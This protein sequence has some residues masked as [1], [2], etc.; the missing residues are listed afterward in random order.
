MTAM[1]AGCSCCVFRTKSTVQSSEATA[2][3]LRKHPGF[4]FWVVY[5]GAHAQLCAAAQ[6]SQCSP[7]VDRDKLFQLQLAARL[8]GVLLGSTSTSVVIKA[9]DVATFREGLKKK[10]VPAL[11]LFSLHAYP[12]IQ[13]EIEMCTCSLIL[14]C[15]IKTTRLFYNLNVLLIASGRQSHP[16]VAPNHSFYW[17]LDGALCVCSRIY[18]VFASWWI[19]TVI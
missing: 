7:Y 4:S 1:P 14:L 3:R 16:L 11:S 13:L 9:D 6:L 17:W 19:P 5:H 2:P 18:W 10:L 8:V 12:A 15:F